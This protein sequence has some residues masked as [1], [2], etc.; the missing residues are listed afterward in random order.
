MPDTIQPSPFVPASQVAERHAMVVALEAPPNAGKT[1][2]GCRLAKGAAEAQGKRWAVI[3]TEGGRTLHVRKHF[4]F[5]IKMLE[6]PHRPEKYL[7][8]AQQAQSDG[9]G[10][11]LIDSFSNVWRGIGGVLHWTDE[12]LEAYVERERG[13]AEYYKRAFDETYTRNKGKQNA[14]IRPKTAFKFMMAGLLDLRIPI[15]L[16]VRGE[17]TYDPTVKKEIFKTHMQKGLGFDVTCRFRL[18]PD[19]KGVIDITDSEK[20][21][22]EGDH[23]AIFRN[24]E[25][26][27]ERHG[28]ALEAWARNA[29]FAVS[30]QATGTVGGQQQQASPAS[31]AD[32]T[33]KIVDDIIARI[34]GATTVDA[35]NAIFQEETVQKQVAWLLDK[36]PDEHARLYAAANAKRAELEKAVA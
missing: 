36:R 21:K 17:L 7:E 9:F 31:P 27:S 26:I 24:G 16:S 6:P 18:M 23:A 22:M 34:T 29:D 19:K 5:S 1:W 11:V 8:A 2:S 32:K 35:I 30:Q 15:I 12:E 20:F 28:A 10:A 14:L 33:K 4:D 25:Q 3:D 13:Q